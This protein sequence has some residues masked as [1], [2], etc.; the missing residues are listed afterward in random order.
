MNAAAPLSPKPERSAFIDA[1]RIISAFGIV[2]FH[3]RV[4][5][6]EIRSVFYAGLVCFIIL[7]VWFTLRSPAK[8]FRGHLRSLQR[9]LFPWAVWFAVFWMVF[10]HRDLLSGRF[11]LGDGPLL[12]RFLSGPALH[13]WYPPFM[14]A[15]TT[16]LWLLRRQI[17]LAALE[18][19]AWIG[20]ILLA[21]SGSQWRAWS[22][23]LPAPLP[24]YIHSLFPALAAVALHC[25]EAKGRIWG[26]LISVISAAALTALPGVGVPYLLGFC[27]CVAAIRLSRVRLPG[28]RHLTDTA[29]CM[30][31]VYLIHPMFFNPS[32]QLTGAD[33]MAYP[34]LVFLVSL[35][36]VKM[37]QWTRWN[38]LRMAFGLFPPTGANATPGRHNTPA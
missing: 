15:L 10:G 34:M 12:W 26:T 20:L 3:S 5:A 37:V 24:Q 7:S 8:D 19:I 16:L 27:L 17:S 2:A 38:S 25:D 4:G 14:A 32:R 6:P 31:G 35:A 33:G 9:L 22:L 30:F 36:I 13:L 11:S 29:V 23:D 28:A 21:L 1:I 18:M